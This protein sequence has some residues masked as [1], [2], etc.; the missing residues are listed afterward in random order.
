MAIMADLDHVPAPRH[1][2]H[3]FLSHEAEARTALA[4]LL[5]SLLARLEEAGWD[6][7][8]A[9]STLMFL[10]AHQVSAAEASGDRKA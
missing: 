9:A 10:A 5:E 6:R 2:P 8:T 4:P 3:D 7:R 1:P